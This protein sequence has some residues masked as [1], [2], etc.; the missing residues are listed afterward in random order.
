MSD[1]HVLSFLRRLDAKLDGLSA[2]FK[3]NF[4]LL[5]ARIESIEEHL[6]VKQI[7]NHQNAT[8]STRVQNRLNG[9]E[10]GEK[11]SH[12]GASK[13]E[14]N[15]FSSNNYPRSRRGQDADEPEI[16][17]IERSN[18]RSEYRESNATVGR[19]LR[20]SMNIIGHEPAEGG[21]AGIGHQEAAPRGKTPVGDYT[22][23][24]RLADRIEAAA[25]NRGLSDS[26][27][28]PAPTTSNPNVSK[29]CK[30]LI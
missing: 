29:T 14:D 9:Q 23:G 2:D 7:Q 1:E 19:D 18:K 28:D 5:S 26:I 21:F 22:R 24:S 17:A 15:G 6:G 16:R 13:G 4:R 30:G 27:Q 8:S 25:N 20:D 10:L 11:H 3:E 12:L